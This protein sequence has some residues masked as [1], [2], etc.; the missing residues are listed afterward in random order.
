[1]S[2]TVS[3]PRA[4]RETTKDIRRLHAPARFSNSDGVNKYIVYLVDTSRYDPRGSSYG[5]L[6]KQIAVYRGMSDT[7]LYMAKNHAAALNRWL[8]Q[9]HDE[10]TP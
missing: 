8:T 6:L 4:L 1:M 9:E 2:Q 7:S 3:L 10:S 5:P